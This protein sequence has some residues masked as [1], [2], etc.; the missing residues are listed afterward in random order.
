MRKY[1]KAEEVKAVLSNAKNFRDH[2][3]LRLLYQTGMR[4][5]ELEALKIRDIDLKEK[6]ISIQQAKRHA[7]GR[8]VPLWDNVT[9]VMLDNHIKDRD[10]DEPLFVS[11]KDSP[12]SKRQI[13]R[14]FEECAK[15][16]GIEKERRHIHILRHTHA[17]MAL[18][19]GVDLRTLQMNLGHTRIDITA[20]YLSLDISDR[21]E[22]YQNHPLPTI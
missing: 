11:N 20:I 13:Q 5:G 10:K 8:K 17:V 22:V 6:E 18:K 15:A 19:S 7:E 1:L 3:M 16:A 21:K 9:I 12:I 14:I 2:L 4:V